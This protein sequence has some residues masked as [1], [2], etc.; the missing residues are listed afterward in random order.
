MTYLVYL[1]ILQS[2]IV[3]SV[4]LNRRIANKVWKVIKEKEKPVNEWNMLCRR[5]IG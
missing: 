2:C 3:K 4:T 5:Y 1:Q